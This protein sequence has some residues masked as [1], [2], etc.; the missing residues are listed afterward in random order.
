MQAE[1]VKSDSPLWVGF[2]YS[3]L[4]LF[5]FI[6]SLIALQMLGLLLATLSNNAVTLFGFYFSSPLQGFLLLVS[7]TLCATLI[8][9]F[10][11]RKRVT[12]PTIKF[13]TLYLVV[14]A[15]LVLLITLDS[16]PEPHYGETNVDSFLSE[17]YMYPILLLEFLGVS[18][19]LLTNYKK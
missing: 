8:S 9:F 7:S 10:T 14:F 3:A 1:I 15:L 18:L 12:F 4:A 6:V 16:N 11:F 19:W 2:K 13:A 17:L 5:F